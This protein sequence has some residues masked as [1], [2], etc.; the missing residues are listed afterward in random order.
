MVLGSILQGTVVESASVF[1][2]VVVTSVFLDTPDISVI[3]NCM[4]EGE[5]SSCHLPRAGLDDPLFIGYETSVIIDTPSV[6]IK[7]G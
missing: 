7:N 4:Y 5:S 2:M 3:N 1:F 6:S